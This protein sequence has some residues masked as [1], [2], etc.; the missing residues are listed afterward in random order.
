MKRKPVVAVVG[1]PNVGKSTLF[2]V[3]SGRK[4]SIV[5]D[6]P[7][8]TRDRIYAECEWC[9][10]NFSIVDTGG[11]DFDEKN[12][13]GVHIKEQVQIAVDIA[14]CIIFVVDGT[15]G[16]TANDERVVKLL[17]S[18]KKPVVLCVN[19]LDNKNLEHNNLAEFYKLGLGQPFPVSCTQKSGLGDMLDAVLPHIRKID[20]ENAGE[21]ERI[22]II[23]KPNAGKSSII[24]ALL[25]EKRV[26]VSSISGT[27]RDAVDTP[28]NYNGKPYILTDTAGIRRKRSVEIE[29]VEHY[30]VLRAISAI[31]NSDA[32]VL[33]IDAA[34]GITEQD[35]R[36]AGIVHEEGKPSVIAVNKWDAE[37]VFG[38]AESPQEKDKPYYQLEF[39]KKL[40]RDLAFMPYFK[41]IY[42][43]ALTGKRIGEVMQAVTE[44]LANTKKRITTGQ[45]NTVVLSAVGTTPPPMVGGKRPKFLYATQAAVGPPTFVLFAKNSAAVQRQYLRYIENTI[46]KSVD[47]TGTPIKIFV[48]D[49][50]E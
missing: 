30:S 44:V 21:T 26:M 27:T 37:G 11:V 6:E 32:A 17:R 42:I 43:S 1:R 9:G 23:G 20:T 39:Q 5:D 41:S 3:L 31:K 28:F 7:G 29:T 19:K 46:R 47:F 13:F 35:V 2:N 49:K 12:A 33:V 22:A 24:N 8:V 50:E 34:D 48:R 10:Y 36:L 4:I 15:V 25:G 38:Q 16:I 14:D 45:L 40:Q 18:S